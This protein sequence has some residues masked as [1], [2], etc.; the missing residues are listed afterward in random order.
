MGVR[1]VITL[2]GSRDAAGGLL[3]PHPYNFT[4]A[5]KNEYREACLRIVD[6]LDLK[7]T[8]YSTE[9]WPNTFYYQPEDIHAFLESVGDPRVKLHLDQMNLVSQ[10]N[11]FHT[12]ELINRTFDLL[13]EDIV[14]VHAK[15]ILWDPSYMFM[16]LDEV[17]AGN[18]VLDYDTFLRQ[19]DALEPDMPVYAEHFRTREEFIDALDH[20]HRAAEKAGVR[21]LRRDEG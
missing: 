8:C 3:S 2:V 18:G 1:C 19:L 7:K 13:A 14:S 17:Y 5:A 4:D 16:K 20:L 9:P 15:D 11:Y 12:T 10:T 21:F 6:G